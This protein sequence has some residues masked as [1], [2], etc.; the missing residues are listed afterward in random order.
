M[1]VN[2]VHESEFRTYTF[3]LPDGALHGRYSFALPAEIQGG[4]LRSTAK[5]EK[6]TTV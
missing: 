3:T 2:A 6:T 1:A 5:P 4:Q